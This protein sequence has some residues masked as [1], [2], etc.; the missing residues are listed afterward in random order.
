MTV[1]TNLH[2]AFETVI[3][4]AFPVHPMPQEEWAVNTSLGFEAR[5]FLIGKMWPEVI[6][7]RLIY[8]ELDLSLSIWMNVLPASIFDY[9]LPSHLV[10]ASLLLRN[11]EVNY[12]TYVMEALILP[13]SMDIS[14][15]EEINEE[16]SLD[17]PVTDYAEA[18]L[19]L[20]KRMTAEQRAGIAE[21]LSLYLEYYK[22][23]FTERGAEL[24]LQIRDIWRQSLLPA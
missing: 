21:Y 7:Y 13:P 17:A 18:R 5:K 8:G 3:Y 12:P 14:V 1:P 15:Q 16:L 20:Y 19:Q 10:L 4:R 9:Y 23:T 2:C 22:A 6:G 11:K 24:F